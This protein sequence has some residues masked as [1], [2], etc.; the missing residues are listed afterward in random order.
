MNRINKEKTKTKFVFLEI[1]GLGCKELMDNHILARFCRGFS[2]F[3][4]L[5]HA[6]SGF[7]AEWHKPYIGSTCSLMPSLC[8]H[9]LSLLWCVRSKGHFPLIY[10]YIQILFLTSNKSHFLWERKAFTFIAKCIDLKYSIKLHQ[11]SL[12]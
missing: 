2:W 4:R 12:F 5:R 10:Y 6:V 9:R 3:I 1:W 11:I 8:R 7:R